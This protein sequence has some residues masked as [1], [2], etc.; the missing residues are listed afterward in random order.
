MLEPV[1]SLILLL[2][3]FNVIGVQI[4]HKELFRPSPTNDVFIVIAIFVGVPFELGYYTERNL[5]PII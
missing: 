4:F 2:R 3:P 5:Q 1:Q